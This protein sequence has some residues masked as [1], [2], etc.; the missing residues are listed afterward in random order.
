MAPRIGK[1][2]AFFLKTDVAL[3]NPKEDLMSDTPTLV[4]FYSGWETAGTGSDGMPLYKENIMIR[5]DRPP[6]LSVTRVAEDEDFIYHSMAFELFQKEQSARKVSYSEGYPLALWPAVSEAEFKMLV[7][8]DIVTVEQLAKAKKAD[9]PTAL[10]ELCDRAAKLVKLQA[11]AAKYEELLRDRDGRIEALEEQVKEAV[12]T[13]AS[14]KTLIERL[15][16][17]GAG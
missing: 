8:R 15:S 1:G 10:K 16:I 11:G 7:D 6:F 5:L 12:I 14:Q 9:M 2:A 17:R 3:A 4:R 13:I